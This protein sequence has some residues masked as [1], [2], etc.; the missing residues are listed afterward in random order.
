MENVTLEFF[1]WRLVLEF[2]EGR[3]KRSHDF[4]LVKDTIIILVWEGR[5]QILMGEG[6]NCTTFEKRRKKN[7]GLF[8][9][10]KENLRGYFE[11]PRRTPSMLGTGIQ[12]DLVT[13]TT[14]LPTCSHLTI[15]MH[16]REIHGYMIVSGMESYLE[17]NCIH[18]NLFQH[19]QS[20]LFLETPK[21]F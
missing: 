2:S 4:G 13:V 9:R 17:H 12:L 1:G 20:P 19:T 11:E 15:L 16:G 5:Y 3:L 7:G 18:Q 14:V 8:E 10:E 21:R 6:C